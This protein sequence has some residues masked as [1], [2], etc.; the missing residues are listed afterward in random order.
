MLCDGN[1]G[2]PATAEAAGLRPPPGVG[3]FLLHLVLHDLSRLAPARHSPHF[4]FDG[5]KKNANR[6]NG[7]QR[8]TSPWG[9]PMT[10]PAWHACE[11]VFVPM[12]CCPHCGSP[13]P[14]VIR[15]EKGG[16]GSL[17]R[18][19]ICRS[20]SKRFVVVVEPPEEIIETLPNSGS[21]TK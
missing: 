7:D 16:D 3:S 20:C 1:S 13:K 11:I 14:I 18:K 6:S 15:S 8:P 19:S 5:S 9:N 12:V 2:G 4:Y 21:R 17:S 10:A